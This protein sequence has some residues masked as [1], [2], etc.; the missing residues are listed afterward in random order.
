MILRLQNTHK[1][2]PLYPLIRF[3]YCSDADREFMM[4]H[5]QVYLEEELG[6][7]VCIHE[8]DF[9]PGQRILANIQNAIER[10]RRTI[11]VIS[12]SVV[13]IWNY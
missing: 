11:A 1:I 5:V 3:S 9:M 4:K 8:R 7:S 13:A 10:S 6:F 12:R 2:T